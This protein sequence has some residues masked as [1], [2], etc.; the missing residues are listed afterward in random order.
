ME[1]NEN[2]H[3]I[4]G[5]LHVDARGSVSFVND[6]DFKGVDRFYTIRCHRPG[7]PRGWVGHR[8]DR[9]WFSAVQGTILVAVVKPDLWEFPTS[10]LPVERFVL[11]SAK[12]AVLCVPSGY[13]TAQVSLT[14][15]AILMVF[16]SG[17]IAQAKEDD[18]RFPP[19]T[20]SIDQSL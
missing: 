9:K 10:N 2:P 13:A 15:D 4:P 7:E 19:D 8:R 5:G 3:L 20:W 12:P 6:F 18:F 17:T 14:G 1:T 16:S 11:S